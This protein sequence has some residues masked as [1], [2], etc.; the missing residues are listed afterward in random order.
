MVAFSGGVESTALLQYVKDQEY[1]PIALY[2]VFPQNTNDGVQANTINPNIQLICD[3]LD[4]KL[5]IHEH[6]RPFILT[7]LLVLYTATIGRPYT[8]NRDST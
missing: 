8:I 5:I 4:V 7:S 1:D 3:Q 2:S 6:Q